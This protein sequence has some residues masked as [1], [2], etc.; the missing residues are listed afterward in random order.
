MKRTPLGSR[1]TKQLIRV[2]DQVCFAALQQWEFTQHLDLLAS[3]S[4]K[5]FT[6]A[7]F[8]TNPFAKNIYRRL[9]LPPPVPRWLLVV[10]NGLTSRVRLALK[11]QRRIPFAGAGVSFRH[12]DRARAGTCATWTRPSAQFEMPPSR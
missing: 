8:T 7:A 4:P 5:E 6:T 10:G 3:A 9:S 11:A 1:F 12:S 2:N